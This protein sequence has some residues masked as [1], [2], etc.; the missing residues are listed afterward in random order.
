MNRCK[1]VCFGKRDFPLSGTDEKRTEM[2]KFIV[3]SHTHWDREWYM[4]F[5][6]FRL[7]LADLIDRLFAVLEKDPILFFISTRRRWCWKIISPFVLR[8]R[9]N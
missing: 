5:S 7:K 8:T 2:K 6:V 3:I 4:P 9:K 1:N